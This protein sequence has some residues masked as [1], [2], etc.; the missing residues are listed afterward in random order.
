MIP[1]VIEP[2]WHFLDKFYKQ[3]PESPALDAAYQRWRASIP[4]HFVHLPA[5]TL[6]TT[7]P[8]LG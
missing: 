2:W 4:E 5:E 6:P 8:V 1:P 3:L 7:P